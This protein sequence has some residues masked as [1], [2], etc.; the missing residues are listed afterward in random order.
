MVSKYFNPIA[1]VMNDV[2]LDQKLKVKVDVP[3]RHP[4]AFD[5][6]LPRMIAFTM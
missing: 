5:A 1:R 2:L 4:G 3:K 6:F